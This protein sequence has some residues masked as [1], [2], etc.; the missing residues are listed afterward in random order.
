MTPG[1]RDRRS[2]RIT[3]LKRTDDRLQRRTDCND[4]PTDELTIDC[5]TD[6]KDGPT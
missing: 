5:R 6:D 1:L 4:E 3:T 2:S